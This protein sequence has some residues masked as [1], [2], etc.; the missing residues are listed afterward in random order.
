MT[1]EELF[2]LFERFIITTPDGRLI[3]GKENRFNRW[4]FSY[5]GKSGQIYT[6]PRKIKW[7]SGEQDKRDIL[8]DRLKA[9][10]KEYTDAIKEIENFN[11]GYGYEFK[12]DREIIVWILDRELWLKLL[13]EQGLTYSTI[14]VFDKKYEKKRLKKGYFKSVLNKR[15]F[16]LDLYDP[17]RHLD[18][19]HDG[20]WCHIP[21]IDEARDEYLRLTFPG[22]Q[23]ERVVD[24]KNKPEDLENLKSVFKTYQTLLYKD[25]LVFRF[26]PEIIS[27]QLTEQNQDITEIITYLEKGYRLETIQN[28]LST[29]LYRYKSKNP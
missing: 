19:E 9:L 20:N 7:P 1:K 23:I 24:F 8:D 16:R 13:E 4:M 3:G 6:A 17:I 14:E 10:D 2:K 29:E 11:Y 12:F 22:I 26:E 18:L 21:E 27:Q 5:S 25:P 15:Y 28:N